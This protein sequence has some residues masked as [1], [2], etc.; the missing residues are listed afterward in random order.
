VQHLAFAHETIAVAVGLPVQAAPVG[1]YFAV[2]DLQHL[3]QALGIGAQ[4]LARVGADAQADGGAGD[5]DDHQHHHQ[6][7]QGKAGL[8]RKRSM[9]T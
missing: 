1:Q 9:C 2:G 4:G 3:G 5:A 8:T 6:F 7:D